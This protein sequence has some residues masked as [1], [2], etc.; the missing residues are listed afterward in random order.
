M[1]RAIRFHK[2]GG[3]EV[4][5]WEE[6]NVGKPGAGEARIRHTAVGLNFVDIY[7]RSGLYPPQQLPSGLGGE[8]AIIDVEVRRR[9]GAGGVPA[10]PNTNAGM[11]TSRGEYRNAGAPGAS[12]ATGTT[13]GTTGTPAARWPATMVYTYADLAP[14]HLGALVDSYGYVALCVNGA[15]AAD[16]LDIKEQDLVLLR[17]VGRL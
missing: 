13:G 4:L 5:T 11:T 16:E 9:P 17:P 6:V 7:N 8:G 3:P 15:S 10:V 12:G 14:G 1:T 2:T